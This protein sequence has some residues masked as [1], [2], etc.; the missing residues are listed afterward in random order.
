MERSDAFAQFAAPAELT[1]AGQPRQTF[2]ISPTASE[3]L[4][5]NITVHHGPVGTI[6]RFFL[7]AEQLAHDCGV[8]L[9]FAPM[10]AL[11]DANLANR[12]S[13]LPLISIF[14]PTL[15]DLGDDNAFCILGHNVHGDLV[16]TQ[17]GRLFD[18][19]GTTLRREA[20]SLRL[21]YRDGVS[22]ARPDEWCT[23]SA[24]AAARIRG[25]VLFSGAA[26]YRPDIRGSGLSQILPRISRVLGHTRWNTNTTITMM[27]G[28]NMKR[29]VN[30]RNG[31]RHAEWA[32]DMDIGPFGPMQLALL[33][34]DTADTLA[35]LVDFGA[36]VAPEIELH[37]GR[38]YAE[39]R[40]TVAIGER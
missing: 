3:S 14:D 21:F 1:H 11:V 25:S 33:W 36:R 10:A 2:A 16:A 28:G 37:V 40:G 24:P 31:Y 23:M 8:R 20:E 18:W 35:D 6:G 19:T 4:N 13:W 5:T 38:R 27:G 17:A 30:V 32:A 29:R 34:N 15:N 12:D 22:D 9:S 39:Q 26:W 7:Q